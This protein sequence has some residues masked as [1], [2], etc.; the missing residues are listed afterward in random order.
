MKVRGRGETRRKEEEGRREGGNR[1]EEEGG[2]REREGET[3]RGRKR[4]TVKS[5]CSKGER[6]N[7]SG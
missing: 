4:E 1:K 6:K 5:G 3:E 7:E 2:R